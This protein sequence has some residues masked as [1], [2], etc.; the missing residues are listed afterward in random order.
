MWMDS[1]L[2]RKDRLII[3]AVEILDELGIQGLSTRE[4][5]KRE[6]VSE[7][8]LF[9]HYKNKNELL[10]AVLDYYS[11]Y[12][13]DIYQTSKLRGLMPID[14][15]TFL[16]SSSVEYYENYPAI[17]SIMQLLDVLRY[18]PDLKEKVNSIY[19]NHNNAIKQLILEAQN[20][21]QLKPVD[22]ESLSDIINGLC[23]EICLKWRLE[24]RSFSL[25]ERTLYSLKETLDA[26]RVS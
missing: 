13:A 10:N 17:T 9:R 24:G 22:P 6:G 19:K 15:I 12:D 21:K 3:T 20:C 23:R 14:A 2:H 5:A 26:F 8:T 7:A 1:I 25:K 16:I 11:L 18:D 4:I